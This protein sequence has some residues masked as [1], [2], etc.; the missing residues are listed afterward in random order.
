M[1]HEISTDQYEAIAKLRRAIQR[2]D[3]YGAP[4]DDGRLLIEN[5]HFI[6]FELIDGERG[7]PVTLADLR[8]II[9]H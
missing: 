7:P 3:N 4:H 8:A 1:P 5:K 9:N 2:L 6:L